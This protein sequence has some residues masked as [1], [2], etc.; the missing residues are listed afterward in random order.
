LSDRIQ[1]W[2]ICSEVDLAHNRW[3]Q[4][5]DGYVEMARAAAEGAKRADPDCV[6]GGV[7]VS[8]SDAR[9]SPRYP[10]ARALWQRLG[11]DL[12]GMF[13]D[14]YAS[15]RYFGPGLNVVSPAE[16]DL[17][18]K[19]REALE[20]VRQ[21]GPEKRIAIEEKGWAIQPSLDVYNEYSRQM[22]DYLARSFIVARSVDE[23]ERYMWF[24]FSVRRL[25][26]GQSYSL[27]RYEGDYP[28]PRPAAAAYAF[29]S[30]LLGGA[31]DP[32]TVELHKDLRAIVFAHG[33]GSR[34]ALWTPREEPVSLEVE[35]PQGVRVT[36]MM[37]GALALDP[38]ERQRLELSGS[39]IY[40]YAEQTPAGEL[41]ARL[42]RSE[43]HLPAAAL[44]V[45][46]PHIDLAR[47]SVSNQLGEALSGSVLLRAPEG[48]SVTPEAAP[49][50]LEPGGIGAVEFALAGWPEALPNTPGAFEARLRTE[51]HGEV[52]RSEEPTLWTV[53]R[54]TDAPAI[55]GDL[56]EYEDMPSI[57]LN[58]QAALDPPDAVANRLWTSTEDLSVKAHLAWDAEN[59]Y[60]AAR[61]TDEAH[62]Q[63]Q[64][65]SR[66]WTNDAIQFAVDPLNDA[67]GAHFTSVSGYN[68]ND[69]EFGL[70]LTPE[71][72]VVW[73]WHGAAE[74]PVEGAE[75]AVVRGDGE[76]VYELA[77]PW[78][79]L[80][81]RGPEAGMAMGVNFIVLDADAPGKRA[82]YWMGPTEGIAGG[83]NPAAFNT[84]VLGE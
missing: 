41:A 5:L 48:V 11:D 60:F 59:L 20:I 8:G 82:L 9:K 58:T 46:M 34:A 15:P 27:F 3:Q 4:G 81:D 18:G 39:P 26:G 16:N 33:Q 70:A 37:G 43:F 78:S 6:I 74:G 2:S 79:R 23:C 24:Q 67:T 72:P 42:E 21:T 44:A 69:S 7:G 68:A 83:K 64:T 49:I 32:R 52:R 54:L 57:D 28:N 29:V 31:E 10:V 77:L 38:G 80:T 66:I 30:K 17:A 19:L 50:E 65:G 12:D 13:F 40:V 71:G 63:E 35:L 73:Q 55:D 76:T 45:T 1:R 14:L 75:L 25:A 84:F 47:V 62:I 22:A 56:A 53:S 36:D 51:A 61:V